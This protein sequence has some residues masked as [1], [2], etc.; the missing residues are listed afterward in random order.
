[1]VHHDDLDQRSLALHV[2]VAR[3]VEAN[4][5]LIEKAQGVVT[6]WLQISDP[7]SHVYLQEWRAVLAQG[8]A[9]SV[10]LATEHSEHA[11]A[12]RQAS[13]MACLLSN[14]ER[15]AFLREWKQAHAT[16]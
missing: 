14:Q 8:V 5:A 15:F 10:R 9:A 7:A 1:M 2:L 6:R 3:K 13:P 16:Q 11:N 12:L 4:P